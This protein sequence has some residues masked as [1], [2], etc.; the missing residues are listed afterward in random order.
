VQFTALNKETTLKV[1]AGTLGLLLLLGAGL[2]AKQAKQEP[3]KGKRSATLPIMESRSETADDIINRGDEGLLEWKRRARYNISQN[4]PPTEKWKVALTEKS[5]SLCDL[6]LSH[7]NFGDGLPVEKSDVVITGIVEKAEAFL[8]A[9]HGDI[10]SQF[11]IRATSTLKHTAPLDNQILIV[12]RRGG[13]LRFKNGKV[14]ER[15]NC[16]EKMPMV[17]RSYLFFLKS[18]PS[19]KDFHII[20]GYELSDGKVSALDGE[21]GDRGGIQSF[22]QHRQTSEADLLQRVQNKVAETKKGGDQ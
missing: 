2:W 1:L 18:Q 21:S 19:T 20:T 3:E 22:V 10:F 5:E 6:P 14:V 11:T 13:A 8:S 17:G 12:E 4:M 9:D 15:G 7:A 16:W